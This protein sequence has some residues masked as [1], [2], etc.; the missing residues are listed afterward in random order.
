MDLIEFRVLAAAGILV[1]GI[2]VS[3]LAVSVLAVADWIGRLLRA[4]ETRPAGGPV[5]G[6]RPDLGAG[7]VRC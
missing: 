7:R 3:A 2:V 6:R 4:R 5:V 1:V